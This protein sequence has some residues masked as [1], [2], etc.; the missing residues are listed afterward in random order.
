MQVDG[1]LDNEVILGDA[2]AEPVIFRPLIICLSSVL[3]T[4]I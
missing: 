4:E 2:R 1:D 3:C